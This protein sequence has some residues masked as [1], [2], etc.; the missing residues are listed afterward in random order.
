MIRDLASAMLI[1]LGHQP[2][3]AKNGSQALDIYKK[4]KE[5]NDPID[6]VI[7]DLVVDNGMGG[8]DAIALLVEFDPNVKAIVSSGYSN[9]PVMSNYTEY[10]FIA[11][12]AKPH[13][14]NEL[15]HA[16]KNLFIGL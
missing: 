3:L 2:V 15:N 9:D 11:A 8:K 12:V 10:G 13:G 1:Q 7:L 6:L 16:L 5:T 4:S 14:I